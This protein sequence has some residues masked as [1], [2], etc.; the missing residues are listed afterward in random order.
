MIKIKKGLD[1]PIQ[2]VPEQAIYDAPPVRSVALLGNDY[3]GMKPTMV[4]REGDRIKTGDILFSDKKTVGVNYTSPASGKVVAVNRGAKRK[5]LSVVIEVDGDDQRSFASFDGPNLTSLS[6]EQVQENLLESGL[7]TAFRQRPFSRVP[8][9]ESS[10]RS[11]FVTAM[12]TLPL[13]AA[14]DVVLEEKS[15]LFQFGLQAICPLTEGPVFLCHA[16]GAD[17]PGQ[18]LQGITSKVFDGPHPAGLP[19]T[20]IHFLD[21]VNEKKSVWY[22]GYQDVIAIGYLFTQG[23]L[24]TE[25]IVALGGPSVK[26]PRLLKTRLGADLSELT[27][28]ELVDGELRVI[29]GSVLA[30]RQSKE[31]E[32][33]LGRYHN[34]VSVIPEAVEREFL[35]WQMPGMDKFSIK[36]VFASAVLGGGKRFPFSTSTNGSHRSM[37]PI[38]SYEKVMPLDIL[39]TQLLRALLVGDTD[40]AQAL[41]CLELDEEDLALCT[42]VDPGKHEFGPILRKNLTTIEK[43]G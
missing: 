32:N 42:F 5:F 33:F 39:P 30:G 23:K 41:G 26:T 7:W 13:S 27:E 10:P 6:R 34:Q 1:L 11:I 8:S 20:H 19:G 25:R 3:I 15:E 35:G 24:L 28:N 36:P 40:Q 4:V 12:D 18:D 43:E 22:I 2:G 29:S 16:A 17:V 38:G 9:P 37:V 31:P 14:V 21:P